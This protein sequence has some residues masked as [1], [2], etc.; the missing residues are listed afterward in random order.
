MHI[1][2]WVS[3]ACLVA[4]CIVFVAPVRAA[5]FGEMVQKDGK[6]VF[7]ST[8]DP[9]LK[10]L[11]KKGLISD[12]EYAQVTEQVE[13]QKHAAAPR[14]RV[15][16]NRGLFF[17]SDKFS[18]K[19]RVRI[20]FRFIDDRFNPLYDT[21]GDTRNFG[22]TGAN[23]VRRSEDVDTFQLRRARLVFSGH[24]FSPDVLYYFQLQSE[25]GS[26]YA[27]AG[28]SMSVTDAYVHL[29]Q[30][31]LANLRIG[32]HKPFF[33]R[34]QIVST[35]ELQFVDRA[36]VHDAFPANGFERRDQGITLMTDRS[37][38]MLNYQIGVYNGAGR[39]VAQGGFASPN[40]FMYVGRLEADLL[41]KPGYD[42]GDAAY[43]V[44][45]QLSVA[46]AY[47]YNPGLD[48]NNATFIGAATTGGT[49]RGVGNGRLAN[50]GMVDLGT[51][52][53]EGVFKYLGFSL[54]AEYFFRNQDR[55]T[56]TVTAL[57]PTSA[58]SVGNATG[59]YA[60]SGYYVIPKKLEFQARYGWFDPDTRSSQDLIKETAGGAH[61]LF[62]GHDQKISLE[63]AYIIS[64]T[65]SFS[66]GGRGDL[67]ENRVRIQ[68]Q[69]WF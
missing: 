51:F 63:Y 4:A 8:E 20:Q 33:N 62:D 69:L 18:L 15:G 5:E 23:A 2:R 9:V 56:H 67:R 38:Y 43:S 68:Y 13:K 1:K 41:G 42:Q 50:Q 36:I 37:K 48:T 11:Q 19:A 10:L 64:G 7:Q 40:E 61:W 60:Q 58:G 39:T 53:G 27:T 31:P 3:G 54:Q 65:G 17:E 12:A 24:A 57:S 6:W 52:A 28:S 46:T 66:T 25:T 30:L 45:P 44:T 32:L 21:L 29:K 55:H 59:W 26:E 35:G 22:G 34:T 47:A 49:L 14:F 16:Y